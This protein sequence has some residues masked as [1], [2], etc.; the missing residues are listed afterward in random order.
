MENQL[1]ARENVLHLKILSGVVVLFAAVVAGVVFDFDKLTGEMWPLY[2][3]PDQ[4]EQ[5]KHRVTDFCVFW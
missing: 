1:N 4:E 5:K 3:R 2:E